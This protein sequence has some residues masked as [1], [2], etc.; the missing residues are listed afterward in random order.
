MESENR[1]RIL[2]NNGIFTDDYIPQMLFGREE[3]IKE[4]AF[5]IS[6]AAEGGSPIHAWIHGK[7]GTG[8]TSVCRHLLNNISRTSSISGAYVNCWESPSYYSILDR[9]VRDLKILGAEKLNTTFKYERFC[10]HLQGRPFILFLDEIDKIPQKE[11]DNALYNFCNIQKVGIIAIC[12]DK[13]SLLTL[14]ERVS[15]RLNAKKIVFH[16]YSDNDLEAILTQ[17]AI[18]AL[19]PSSYSGTDLKHIAKLSEGDARVAL[20]TLRNAAYIAENNGEQFISFKHIEKGYN[21]AKGMKQAYALSKLTKHHRILFSIIVERGRIL[22]GQLWVLYAKKCS[23]CNIQPIAS[24]T[25]SDYI[26]KL[27]EIGAIKSERAKVKGKVR[28]ICI[29]D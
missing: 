5:C 1:Q 10:R 11:K 16:P 8:K 25:Y 9:L 21:S 27:I 13:Y 14:D 17:R 4:L 19:A 24:R 7:P 26:N 6:P 22:S 23:E 15:S 18:H 2:T 12:N 29:K 20:H 28:L 3:Q